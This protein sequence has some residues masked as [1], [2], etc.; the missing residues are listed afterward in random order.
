M[1]VLDSCW[2]VGRMK[3]IVVARSK[4]GY[5]FRDLEGMERG[6]F[7]FP[8]AQRSFYLGCGCDLRGFGSVFPLDWL[9]INN[10]K[11]VKTNFMQDGSICLSKGR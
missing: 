5:W 10:V 8:N 4:E 11:P 3:F 7:T 6:Q 1:R 9:K 2:T